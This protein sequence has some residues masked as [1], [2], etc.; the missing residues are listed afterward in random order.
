[1]VALSDDLLRVLGPFFCWEIWPAF[2]GVVAVADVS[3]VSGRGCVVRSLSLCG[4]L[5]ARCLCGSLFCGCAG[6]NLNCYELE[7]VV[8][9][10]KHS[11]CAKNQDQSRWYELT[12]VAGMILY[13]KIWRAGLTWIEKLSLIQSAA[14]IPYAR[15]REGHRPE[16]CEEK[17]RRSEVGRGLESGAKK[18][19]NSYRASTKPSAGKQG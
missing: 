11:G 8:N 17:T 15:A 16:S 13:Q 18:L 10:L 9:R 4:G 5:S 7:P 14:A 19:C 1:M 2:L 3:T 6:F 12:N